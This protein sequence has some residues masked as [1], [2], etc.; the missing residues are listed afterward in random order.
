M[1]LMTTDK[2]PVA[3]SAPEALFPNYSTV[4]GTIWAAPPGLFVLFQIAWCLHYFKRKHHCEQ[5]LI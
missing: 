5:L 3:V 1:H 4:E 2:V